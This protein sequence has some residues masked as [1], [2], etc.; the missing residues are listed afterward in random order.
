M[1]T[2][3]E[4]L[5]YGR[6]K[7]IWM[8]YCGFLDL[9]INEFSAI[10]ERLL[11][12][13]MTIL[14]NSI[15]GKKL[16]NNQKITNI[17]EFR[18]IIPLTSYVDYEEHF[19][20]QEDDVLPVKAYLWA[21]T[22]GRSGRFKWVPYTQYA[23][24]KLGERVL[25][26]VI[27]AAARHKGDVRIDERDTL[28]YNTPPR[29][30]ISGVA[31][32]ALAEHF[33]FRFIPSLDETEE[34][35]FQE[36][37]AKGFDAALISGIDVLGSLSVVLVKMGERF[38]EGAHSTKLSAKLLHPKALVR[39]LTGYIRSK[40]ERRN[41]LPKDLWKL[42]ALPC[43]GM[44]TSIYR[45]QIAHYW[46]IQPYEQYGSTEEGSIAT[47]GWNKKGMTF[48]PDAAFL[49]FVPD[50]EW[51]KW[52]S[53]P[54]Y[55]PETKLIN[56]VETNKLYEVVITNYY[57]KPFLRYRMNDI[58]MFNALQDD[59][60]GVNLPQVE[61]V[62]RTND[63]IDLSGFTGL[64]DEKMV[65]QSIVDTDIPFREWT[66]RKEEIKG[67]SLLHLYIELEEPVDGEVVCTK[68]H[69]NLKVLNPFYADYERMIN[70]RPLKV[71]L[72]APNTFQSYTQEMQTAGADLAHL[73]PPH[74]NP[75]K[76][77]L[78]MLLRFNN[79]S[80]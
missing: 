7:E 78:N 69:E 74:M 17:D 25:S 53:D 75:S 9:N 10:Q 43:G 56:E 57:G 30:Y 45:D 28:V 62:G 5:R 63:L 42:K 19:E 36:R 61:F 16:L 14:N 60:T 55:I 18:Q 64:I 24:H 68:V 35:D 47:Q 12:E 32:R 34:M 29:P 72:L 1:P 20:K 49:E 6:K 50:D 39:L 4:L 11:L 73:K 59:E 44:D 23:Y 27:L 31:L 76:D 77:I 46:G 66:I 58:V 67:R 40:V 22:S 15:M 80:D 79:R 70:D 38:A 48:F 54:D 3:A 65:W 13:Q 8:K 2:A 71:T 33:N 26:G 41:L 37:I 21:H 51:I 52:K